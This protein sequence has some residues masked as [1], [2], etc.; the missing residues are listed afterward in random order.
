MEKMVSTCN[1]IVL[2]GEPRKSQI[3]T[4]IIRAQIWWNDNSQFA[5]VSTQHWQL[6]QKHRRPNRTG[7][8]TCQGRGWCRFQDWKKSRPFYMTLFHLGLKKVAKMYDSYI[9]SG[10]TCRQEWRHLSAVGIVLWAS[11][12]WWQ[13]WVLTWCDWWRML[14]RWSTWC[15][16]APASRQSRGTRQASLFPRPKNTQKKMN[17]YELEEDLLK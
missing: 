3:H 1:I 17:N 5:W 7:R 10:S 11:R 14:A 16:T 4:W 6:K 2:V 12:F 15:W 13:C 8:S 9:S